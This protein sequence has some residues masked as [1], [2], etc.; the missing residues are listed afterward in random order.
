MIGKLTNNLLAKFEHQILVGLLFGVLVGA[1]L[2]L[3]GDFT[4]TGAKLV[5]FKW[6]L[7]PVILGLTMMN[8]VLRTVRWQIFL[9]ALG[10][11]IDW[12][13]S[14]WVFISGLAM[15]V[16]PGR[17]G[18][19]IK[20][21][22]LKKM[23]KV[24]ISKTAPLVVFERLSDGLA[25]VVLMSGGLLLTRYGV[26]A[27]GI[28]AGMAGVFVWL[29][30][31]R[32]LV[33]KILSWTLQVPVVAKYFGHLNNFYASSTK[34]VGW[35]PLV[36]GWV[37]SLGAWAAEATGFY[38]VLTGL[39]VEPSMKVLLL[40]VF[41]FGF[42]AIA[43]FATFLPGGLGVNEGTMVG[44][45]ML[46]VGV[47]NSTAAAGTLLIRLMTLWF[48]VLWGMVGLVYLQRRLKGKI[49]NKI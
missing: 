35:R 40:A 15:T 6:W 28:A 20:S 18:E 9:R 39:G 36:I 41:I 48:G 16:T 47:D 32:T 31:Q 2:G 38:L 3:Y 44:L 26:A 13:R 19:L 49:S 30:H 37:L 14:W 1:G 33:E 11:K 34:L 5:E 45:L 22:F 12:R 29:L 17:L 25:M 7:V 24:E 23:A 27:I 46:L 10:I 4:K 8:Y 21:Y 42:A 43:G